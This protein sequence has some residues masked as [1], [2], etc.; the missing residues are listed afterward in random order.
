[1]NHTIAGNGI[2]LCIIT[3]HCCNGAR[4]CALLVQDVVQLQ[5]DGKGL[6]LEEA[7][8]ELGIPDKLV[9]VHRGIVVT[10]TA[11]HVHVGGER[12]APRRCYAHHTSVGKLPGI[13]V[14]AGLQLAT[15]AVVVERSVELDLQP[16]VTI[17]EGQALH[18]GLRLGNSLGIAHTIINKTYVVV[19]SKVSKC[20]HV[21]VA[22]RVDSGVEHKAQV[23]IPVTIDILRTSHTCTT[24][25]QGNLVGDRVSGGREVYECHHSTLVLLE[26]I[27]VEQLEVLTERRLQARV[28]SCNVQG[29]AV[30]Y[31]IQQIAHRGLRGVGTI[32]EAQLTSLRL[33]PTE[34]HGRCKVGHRAGGIGMDTLVVLNKVRL[35]R[36]HLHTNIKGI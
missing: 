33:L 6:T 16:I 5:R 15:V 26:V 9:G 11:L 20:I 29:V 10:T 28:T 21:K 1:M 24:I 27:V 35:L 14:I 25:Q 2:V 13:K 12:C 18:D 8:R 3:H 19:V 23:G 34:V 17:A 32:G 22:S 31:D 30:I 4:Q 7:L 36:H